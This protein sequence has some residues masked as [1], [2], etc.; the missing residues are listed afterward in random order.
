MR[1]K[2]NIT[3]I[4]NSTHLLARSYNLAIR[5]SQGDIALFLDDDVIPLPNL[6]YEHVRVY[7][8]NKGLCGVEGQVKELNRYLNKVVRSIK[9]EKRI[10]PWY[11]P[12]CGMEKFHHFLTVSGYVL[13]THSNT[14]RETLLKIGGNMSILLSLLQDLIID[15]D[16]RH[17]I[18]FETTLCT[19]ILSKNPGCKF[20]YNPKAIVI[21]LKHPRG[22]SRPYNLI[23]A[24]RI[25][26]EILRT[27]FKFIKLFTKSIN[28]KNLVI[29][30]IYEFLVSVKNL[31]YRTIHRELGYY[32]GGSIGLILEFLYY[33]LIPYDIPKIKVI[34]LTFDDGYRGIYKHAFHVLNEYGY[35]G[36][37]FIITGLV[38]DIFEGT[39]LMNI[40]ELSKLLSAGWEIGSHT[41]SHSKLTIL[42]TSAALKELH[43]SKLW[44]EK[45]LG[46]KPISIA[47]PYGNFNSRIIYLVSKYYDYGRTTIHNINTLS[48]WIGNNRL[49][50]HAL[51]VR[52]ENVDEIKRVIQKVNAEGGWL[53]LVFHNIVKNSED[54]PLDNKS[55]SWITLE[56]FKELINYIDK[57]KLQVR[58]FTEMLNSINSL[59][60]E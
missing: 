13:K 15:E 25:K 51:L 56:R 31:K 17:C 33:K 24:Y 23:T 3:H 39:E 38:G 48:S 10:H 18:N 1:S 55:L 52:E 22:I 29:R 11:L 36:V 4:E 6:I 45:Q 14:S 47:Y 43:V 9:N 60:N 54:L 41:H 7:R 35:R 40:S 19:K 57:F 28:V 58:T 5:A 42:N 34:T 21:H 30:E 20:I 49:K 26:R 2:L 32:L 46:Y 37:V 59:P 53:I 44:I 27:S 50:L 12:I 16:Q 8:E